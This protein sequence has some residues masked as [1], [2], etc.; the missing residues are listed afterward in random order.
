MEDKLDIYTIEDEI[1]HLQ[2]LGTFKKPKLLMHACCAPCSTYC[3]D[4]LYPYF[5]ITLYYYNP[6][7]MP[8]EEWQKRAAEFDKLIAKYPEVKLIIPDQSTNEFLD[9]VKGYEK[10]PEGGDRCAICFNHRLNKTAH[11]ATNGFDYFTTHYFL[12]CFGF[13]GRIKVCCAEEGFCFIDHILEL[14]GRFLL[15]A[16]YLEEFLQIGF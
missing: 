5:D 4:Y 14:L 11:E 7:I 1:A 8:D 15:F 13:T 3:V 6:N 2:S 16:G 9:L 12:F 10:C